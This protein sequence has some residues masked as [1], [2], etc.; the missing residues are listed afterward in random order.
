[1]ANQRKTRTTKPNPII[2]REYAIP[3]T[4]FNIEQIL[5]KCNTK[6]AHFN[7]EYN[8][9]KTLKDCIVTAFTRITITD[10]IDNA[11]YKK[12]LEEYYYYLKYCIESNPRFI[13]VDK[14][15]KKLLRD[16]K[17][18]ENIHR[19]DRLNKKYGSLSN[20]IVE[21]KESGIMDYVKLK[22]ALLEAPDSSLD[23]YAKELISKWE[24]KPTAISIL[25]TLDMCVNGSLCSGFCISVMDAML[26]TA[27][28]EENTSLEELN[29]QAYWRSKTM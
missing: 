2:K 11:F 13:K 6:L 25:H 9:N 5:E 4:G 14:E 22:N 17:I 18:K 21:M 10:I 26:K 12:E 23:K 29:K 28:K 8:T 19:A 27:M 3:I 16:L 1:M 20:L 15:T 24:D 7:N